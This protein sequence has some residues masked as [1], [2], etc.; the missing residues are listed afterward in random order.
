[1]KKIRRIIAIHFIVLLL[2][3]V[4]FIY[5]KSNNNIFYNKIKNT[6]DTENSSTGK[7]SEINAFEICSC[8]VDL[9]ILTTKKFKTLN[10]FNNCS[11]IPS[12]D[13]FARNQVLSFASMELDF[14]YFQRNF[15]L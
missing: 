6:L 10:A 1:M 15:H 4:G 3:I 5:F 8:I 11:H 2:I 13:E 12:I 7:L 14:E 9:A